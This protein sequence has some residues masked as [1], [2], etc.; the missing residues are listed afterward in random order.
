[1]SWSSCN[2][3]RS[4]RLLRKSPRSAFRYAEHIRECGRA[5]P[6]Q[7]STDQEH[8]RVTGKRWQI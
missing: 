5:N 4:R 2:S 8:H 7:S 6:A 3:R 1:L